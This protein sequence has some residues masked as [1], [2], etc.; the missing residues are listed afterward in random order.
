MRVEARDKVI[1]PNC[2]EKDKAPDKGVQITNGVVDREPHGCPQ[3]HAGVEGHDDK[4]MAVAPAGEE[5]GQKEEQR[6]EE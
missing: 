6:Y 4:I 1:C 2:P 3:G 5:N